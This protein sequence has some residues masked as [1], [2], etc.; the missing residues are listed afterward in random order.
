MVVVVLQ[1]SGGEGGL[2]S[3][4]GDGVVSCEELVGLYVEDV[5]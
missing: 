2:W 5:L 1:V 3:L 4:E